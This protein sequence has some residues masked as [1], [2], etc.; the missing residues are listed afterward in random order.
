MA[1]VRFGR[2]V[3]DVSLVAFDK[4]G[5]LIDFEHMWGRLAVE[6]A[7]RLATGS[8][9]ETIKREMYR[10]WGYDAQRRR[11]L[12][13]SPF[14]MA[15]TGQ[16]Q[17]IAAATLFRCGVPWPEAEDRARTVF[18]TALSDAGLTLGELVRPAGDVAGLFRQLQSAGVGVAVITT[19]HRADTEESLRLL[20]V[21]ELVDYVVCGDDG[22]PG[23]PA[24]DM[25]LAACHHLAIHPSR[26]AVVG[27]TEADLLMAQ[28]A[29]AG[30]K[31]AVQT[32]PSDAALLAR[33]ADVVLESI[34]D[35]SVA[36]S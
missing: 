29:G 16:V 5:T 7:E 14:A 22:L 15:T 13:L 12:P 11:T 4:D 8:D 33:L 25:L 9:A 24:P 20:D 28:R 10:S 32:G 6:W 31:V 1:R 27:D 23:K 19:D 26:C 2:L 34:D 21:T 36:A 30:L 35:I 3:C 18:Q 17:T